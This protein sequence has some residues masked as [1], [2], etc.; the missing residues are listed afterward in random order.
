[1]EEK[2]FEKTIMN[3]SLE[4]SSFGKSILEFSAIFSKTNEQYTTFYLSLLYILMAQK[5]RKKYNNDNAIEEKN[6]IEKKN[7]I[8]GKKGKNKPKEGMDNMKLIIIRK[9]IPIYILPMNI[10][11]NFMRI[12][13]IIIIIIFY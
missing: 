12:I 3:I 6:K 11:N 10:L 13:I 9:Y 7:K 1:L 4:A 8:E 5:D 2:D